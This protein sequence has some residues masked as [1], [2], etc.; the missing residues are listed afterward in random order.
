[1]GANTNI[2]KNSNR[3]MNNVA[4]YI[5]KGTAYVKSMNK[6]A[7]GLVGIFILLVIGMVMYWLYRAIVQSRK[8]DV[9]NPILVPGSIDAIDSKNS[10]SWKLPVSSN[11]NS[12]SMAFTISFWMY[13]ADWKY[14]FGEPKAIL[15]KDVSRGRIDRRRNP[16]PGIWLDA[17]KNNL[18]VQTSVFDRK[19]GRFQTCNVSNIPIQ[20]WVHVAYV[21]DNR[22][23]DVYVDCKLERSCV[24]T[25]VPKLNNHK[26]H[27]FPKTRNS[28]G[29]TGFSGQLSSLRYFS[30][31][32]RPVDIARLC[33][34][35]PNA[36]KDQEVKDDDDDDDNND[37]NC[38]PRVYTDLRNV[39]NQLV[40]I[41]DEV[42]DALQTQQEMNPGSDSQ[43]QT[44]D[45]QFQSDVKP[46]VRQVG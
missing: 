11:S 24:L 41:T 46:V 44:W 32:L 4:K 14:R 12:P 6:L 31:A 25:G 38:A 8:G 45:V 18:I 2:A 40:S 19:G 26:L 34:E 10:K 39:K 36:T 13:I 33:N 27:L 5:G 35:G 7:V 28:S 29:K 23:V 1:M 30:N 43:S 17:E 42:D 37:D 3:K 22:T 16:A 15:L 9:E 21:L 20:K